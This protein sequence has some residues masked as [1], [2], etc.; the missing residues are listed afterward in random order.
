MNQKVACNL[1]QFTL[2]RCPYCHHIVLK[3]FDGT[4]CGIQVKCRKCKKEVVFFTT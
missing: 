1:E 2:V 3:I 4:K